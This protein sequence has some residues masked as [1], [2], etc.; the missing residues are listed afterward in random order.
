MEA[1]LGVGAYVIWRGVNGKLAPQE[2]LPDVEFDRLSSQ[3]KA[4]Q[5]A[6]PYA[7]NHMKMELVDL[8]DTDFSMYSTEPCELF[9]QL[10]MRLKHLHAV[11]GVGKPTTALTLGERAGAKLQVFQNLKRARDPTKPKPEPDGE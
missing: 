10:S 8:G 5:S 3:A 7:I 2:K 6:T 11:R 4:S 9:A 1:A